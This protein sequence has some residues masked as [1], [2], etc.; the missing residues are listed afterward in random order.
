[1]RAA[2]VGICGWAGQRHFDAYRELGILV[3]YCLDSAPGADIFAARIGVQRV[4]S[5]DA[6][7]RADVELVRV[8]LPPNLQAEACRTLLRSGKAVICEKPIA[9]TAA[10]ARTLDLRDTRDKLMPAF[11]LRFHP[12]YL[13]MKA[14]IDCGEFGPIRELVIDSRVTKVEVDGWRRDPLCGGVMLVNGIH[15]VDLAHWFCAGHLHPVA[16]H[17]ESR[18]FDAPVR[19][20]VHVWLC[21]DNGMHVALRTQ[22]W[23]FTEDIVDSECHDGWTLRV[24]VE[25]DRGVL[26]QTATGLRMLERSGS[27]RFELI[28][29]PNLFTA[30]IRHFVA[31]LDGA[32]PPCVTV[33]DDV[34]AQRTVESIERV[35]V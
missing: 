17:A 3:K 18:F 20:C 9:A 11:L 1:M 34:R 2:V 4:E 24:R 16:S 35:T 25:L 7:A 14:L 5:V 31:A 27:G 19:D 29:S 6:L 21:S 12:V 23:P 32:V 26:I 10:E 33:A 22:W 13:R 15:A 8:A 30:E 28:R